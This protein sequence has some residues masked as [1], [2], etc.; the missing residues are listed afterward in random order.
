MVLFAVIQLRKFP[1]QV[2]FFLFLFSIQ[3]FRNLMNYKDDFRTDNALI[4][5]YP[6]RIQ[7]DQ[8]A[9]FAMTEVETNAFFSLQKKTNTPK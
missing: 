2:R 1:V 7:H 3:R 9:L 8:L 5:V 6:Y 4:S